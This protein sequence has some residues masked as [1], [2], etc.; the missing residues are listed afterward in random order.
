MTEL[1]FEPR[2]S[3]TRVSVP[4]EMTEKQEKIQ[5]GSVQRCGRLRAMA[6]RQEGPDHA[7]LAPS[8]EESG[9][10]LKGKESYSWF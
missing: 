6:G 4:P 2:L 7:H 9:L 5:S 10:D 1:G 3:R 8:A